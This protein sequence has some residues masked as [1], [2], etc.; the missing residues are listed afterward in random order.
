[1]KF[2]KD[3]YLDS[4]VSVAILSNAPLG[5]FEPARRRQAA[6]SRAASTSRSVR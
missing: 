6:H 5:L 3:V 2:V 1:V 4:Q